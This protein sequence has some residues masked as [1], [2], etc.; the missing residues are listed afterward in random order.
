MYYMLLTIPIVV[1]RFAGYYSPSF[2]F[3]APICPKRGNVRSNISVRTSHIAYNQS[4]KSQ[5]VLSATLASCE[6]A[7][8]FRW[9]VWSASSNWPVYTCVAVLPGSASLAEKYVEAQ[10]W[11]EHLTT[12]RQYPNTVCG[13]HIMVWKCVA[14][15]ISLNSEFDAHAYRWP[16]AHNNDL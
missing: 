6:P 15:S 12:Y 14:V 2:A 9:T 4:P 8:I 3:C 11:L 5:E 1:Q 16:T 10:P 13:G 7:L